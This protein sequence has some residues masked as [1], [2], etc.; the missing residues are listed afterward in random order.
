M[1]TEVARQPT[2]SLFMA[3]LQE[4]T[5]PAANEPAA[6]P[7]ASQSIRLNNTF[8]TA[9]EA[10]ATPLTAAAAL[11][12]N[13]VQQQAPGMSMADKQSL[14][15]GAALASLSLQDMQGFEVNTP[16]SDALQLGA[17]VAKLGMEAGKEAFKLGGEAITAIGSV[18]SLGDRNADGIP[19]NQQNLDELNA[20]PARPAPSFAQGLPSPGLG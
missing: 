3:N 17:Q 13:G 4:I 7:Q 18:F 9:A 15:G 12:S 16:G 2:S 14:A 19:D 10:K 11:V 5:Q 20:P 8:E 6:A 1:F